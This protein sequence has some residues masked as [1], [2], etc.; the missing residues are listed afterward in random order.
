MIQSFP[1][2]RFTNK[3]QQT[4]SVS[5]IS[6]SPQLPWLKCRI[7][8]PSP[9]T[10]ANFRPSGSHQRSIRIPPHK[11][12]L[13]A[14]RSFSRALKKIPHP[15]SFLR[16]HHFRCDHVIENPENL[17]HLH[18]LNHPTRISPNLPISVSPDFPT[19]A[20]VSPHPVNL[21]RPSHPLNPGT[22]L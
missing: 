18:G 20:H 22:V 7:C 1:N 21:T 19:H 13:R 16:T 11:I 5:R 8:S 10:S 9:R 2:P 15:S 3:V 17:Y 6:P 12:L 14:R 4:L